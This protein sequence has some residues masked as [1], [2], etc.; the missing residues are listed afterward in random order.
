MGWQELH[1][2]AFFRRIRRSAASRRP[3]YICILPNKW[4]IPPENCLALE[5]SR[6]GTLSAQAAGMTCFTVID[7]ISF[8]PRRFRRYQ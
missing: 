5:D 1:P 8:E 7:H 6:A 2:T 4:A 3:T